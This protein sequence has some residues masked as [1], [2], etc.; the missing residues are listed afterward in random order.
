L[1]LYPEASKRAEVATMMLDPYE[2]GEDK[3]FAQY[4]Y[5]T[6]F[7]ETLAPDCSAADFQKA[8][9]MLV[10]AIDYA[11]KA[12]DMEILVIYSQLQ[13]ARLYLGTTDEYLHVTNDPERIERASRCLEELDNKLRRHELNMRFESLYYLRKSDCHRSRGETMLAKEAAMRAG[14]VATKANLPIEKKAAKTRITYLELD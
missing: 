5:A 8:K 1:K 13:L 6:S 7:F 3:A 14:K 12:I 11:K 4:C 2:V 10:A 9:K